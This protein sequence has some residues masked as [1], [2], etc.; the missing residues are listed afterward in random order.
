MLG[1]LSLECQVHNICFELCKNKYSFIHFNPI[2]IYYKPTYPCIPGCRKVNK[3]WPLGSN[4]K[5]RR[6]KY[7]LPVKGTVNKNRLGPAL[8]LALY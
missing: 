5:Q 8:Y 6:A 1:L 4:N 3:T 2:D 7:Q